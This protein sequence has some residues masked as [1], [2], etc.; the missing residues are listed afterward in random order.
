MV[1]ITI[2]TGAYKPT[3]NWGASHCSFHRV[4]GISAYVKAVSSLDSKKCSNP[5]KEKL[6]TW[7]TVEN[8]TYG[9]LW[10]MFLSFEGLPSCKLSNVEKPP[11]V[12]HVHRFPRKTMAF[13]YVYLR[14]TNIS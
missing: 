7:I 9:Y 10:N 11:L 1:L 12:D 13:P 2:V 8:I 6:D 3:Y 5:Q 14:V 4:Q